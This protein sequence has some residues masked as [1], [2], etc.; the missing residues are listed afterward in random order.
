MNPPDR[1]LLLEDEPLIAMM[2]EDVLDELGRTVA[3]SADTVTKA[4]AL[5]EAG[6]VGAAI[7]DVNLRGGE[8][9]GAIADALARR[10]IPFAFATGGGEDDIAEHHR[11]RPRLRK[12]FTLDDVEKALADL[13]QGSPAPG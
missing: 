4:L 6:G 12:P 5:I 11:A 8:T 1:I 9:S 10:G 3:G 7:L 2:L 13:A